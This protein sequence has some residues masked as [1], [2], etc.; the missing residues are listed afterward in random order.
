MLSV[1][2]II[3]I[4]LLYYLLPNKREG[5]SSNKCF[6]GYQQ[7]NDRCYKFIRQ[8][9]GHHDQSTICKRDKARLAIISDQSFISE[10][11][12][13]D[14]T[15]SAKTWIGLNKKTGVW[16]WSNGNKMGEYNNWDPDEGQGSNNACAYI[17]E[18]GKWGI[19]SCHEKKSALCSHSL[20][21]TAES[22]YTSTLTD[23]S[24][25]EILDENPHSD[26]IASIKSVRN[27]NSRLLNERFNIKR[28]YNLRLLREYEKREKLKEYLLEVLSN[29]KE[30][31][32]P[33]IENNS[34]FCK[35]VDRI[36]DNFDNCPDD[37]PLN[38]KEEIWNIYETEIDGKKKKYFHNEETGETK[39]GNEISTELNTFL[40]GP[41]VKEGFE[42]NDQKVFIQRMKI[43]ENDKNKILTKLYH[44]RKEIMDIYT[45]IIRKRIGPPKKVTITSIEDPNHFLGHH[46]SSLT[47]YS[48]DFSDF[49]LSSI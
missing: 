13:N 45:Q 2:F 42:G 46:D 11:E 38:I 29:T 25:G 14:L 15:L 18:N 21:K 12:L 36:C 40:G 32:K 4:L 5:I 3:A 27:F 44:Q 22:P 16:K 26:N 31:E 33:D 17:K 7:I 30:G 23:E 49:P 39:W 28:N 47:L 34:C 10:N 20:T 9:A 6:P 1:I 41:L 48:S 8:E 24:F 37:E 35:N 43:V 19:D